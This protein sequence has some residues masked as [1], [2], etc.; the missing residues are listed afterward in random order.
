MCFIFMQSIEKL[1]A[2]REPEIDAVPN[3]VTHDI[4]PREEKKKPATSP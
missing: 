2:I 4:E 3:T 1:I